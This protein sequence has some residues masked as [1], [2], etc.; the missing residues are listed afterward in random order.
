MSRTNTSAPYEQSANGKPATTADAWANVGKH[1]QEFRTYLG[2]YLSVQMD[3][4]VLS[5][6]MMVLFAALGMLV[7]IGLGAMLV[8]AAVQICT[9]IAQLIGDALG[10]RMWAGYLITG[11]AI[12]IAVLAVAIIGINSLMAKS[13]KATME[14]YEQKRAQERV[15]VG[16][17]VEQ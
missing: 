3:R 5:L 2:H 6:K 17:D 15:E 14:K 16:H 10:G 11:A 1:W 13:R 12:W 8:T 7:L 4:L 9:G